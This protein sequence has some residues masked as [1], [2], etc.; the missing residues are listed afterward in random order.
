[1]AMNSPEDARGA[2]NAGKDD[3]GD[4]FPDFPKA[5]IEPP[6]G[7]DSDEDVRVNLPDDLETI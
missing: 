1:M 5:P 7:P 4:D 6:L 2:S 3:S